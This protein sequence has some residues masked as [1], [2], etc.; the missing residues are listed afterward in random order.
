MRAIDETNMAFRSW[1]FYCM[2][3]L[4][5]TAEERS[6]VSQRAKGRVPRERSMSGWRRMGFPDERRWCNPACA[7]R[8]ELS[9]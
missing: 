2:L 5:G 7:Y 9:E 4:V 3:T 8:W 6:G 1:L